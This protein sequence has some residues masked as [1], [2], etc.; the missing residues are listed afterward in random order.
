MAVKYSI[1]TCKQL[2]TAFQKADLHRPM[3]VGHYDA[4]IE[5]KLAIT[6]VEPGPNAGVRV[7]IEK[8]VGGGFAGQVYKVKLLSITTESG[9]VEALMNF[10]VG[11]SYAMKILI[12]PSGGAHFFRNLVYV[13]GFQGPFQLQVNPAAS[14]AG[15]LW[16]KFI[17]AAAQHRF[18]DD[19]C[20]NDIHATFV[21]STLGSCGEISDWVEG[22][23]W[24]LEVDD[25]LDTLKRWRKGKPVDENTLGSPEFCSKYTFMTEFVKLLH[26]IGAYE[27]ARQYEWTTCKSQP[28]ALK[29]TDTNDDPTAGLIAV[30]F[31]AGLA[32]L[33]YLPMSPGDFKLIG[34]GL[35]R[36][37]LVQFDRGNLD[38]LETHIN[39]NP[40]IYASLENSQQMLTELKECEK[41]YRD[42]VPDITHNHFRLLTDGGLWNSLFDS[43]VTGWK[44]RN[45]FD[46]EKE[47][48]FRGSKIK[49]FF[50]FLLGLIPF[51]G[52]IPRRIWAQAD[53]RKHYAS[54][55]SSMTYLGRAI[56]AKMAEKLI[57][58]HRAGRVDAD[59]A[60]ALYNNLFRF[61]LHV[62]V[63][64][65]PAGLHRF[66]TNPN[67]LKKKLY[68]IFKRPFKLYFNAHLREQWLRDMVTQGKKKH[69]LS[70]EDA[71]TILSQ[72]NEPYIQKYLVSL[73][74]HLMTLPVTQVVGLIIAVVNWQ[75]RDLAWDDAM[76]Q[77]ALIMGTLQVVPLSPG[78]FCRGLYTTIL[79]IRDRNFKDYNIAL[80][81]S[82]F[83]YIGYLAF[84]IQMTYH[85]PAMARF[86]AAHWATDAVHIVPVFGE[87]G[88]LLEHWIFCLFYNWPLTVRR[89]MQ[90]ISKVRASLPARLWHIP[91]AACL[92]VGIFAAS[93]YGYFIKSGI[94]PTTDNTWFIKPLFCLVF[95]VPLAAGW[96]VTR[97]AG[98]LSRG[99]RV[100]AAAICGL[101]AGVIYSLAA[102]GM[103]QQWD[104]EQ[105]ALLVPMIWRAFAMAIFCTLGAVIAEIRQVDP[106]LK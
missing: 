90:R 35:K 17:R 19:N 74:V 58:W 89:R 42:S 31:R 27:F 21:D 9:P 18:G 69:I 23:T 45:L 7:S 54:M 37:S 56:K 65:F 68:F 12:P 32:L 61:L 13:L 67:V 88:A 1:K 25:R 82:Y 64:I 106:D 26:E 104:L 66:M 41:I 97:F 2:E 95:F 49:T 93:H 80:F 76:A 8:F 10:T 103:E 100:G 11:Q 85:Y 14:R 20:V 4:G 29:R 36:G 55:F 38:I 47:A 70:D 75:V 98:G 44:T 81:L 73:V 60:M 15:A 87:R 5:L 46:P 62:P 99:K 101:I 71:D 39:G 57:G 24:R 105:T 63:S 79:A 59:T 53:W 22:R 72:V 92:A 16:Q 86:M 34:Q 78:S 96:V 48:V 102:F 94:E 51:L 3:H 43:A 28:N 83:K 33:P 30:D 84:P 6:P 52:R 50:F 77:G 40:D 91:A